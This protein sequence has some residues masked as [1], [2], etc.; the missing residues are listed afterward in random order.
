MIT[1]LLKNLQTTTSNKFVIHCIL[2]IA[3]A[4]SG[5]N[6]VK[7]QVALNYTL[8]QQQI[9]SAFTALPVATKTQIF[10]GL[11]DD[12]APVLVTLPFT[13]YFNGVAQT[14]AWVS[15]NGYIT[16]GSTPSATNY[17]P[18]SSSETYQGA[19]AAFGANLSVGSLATTTIASVVYQLNSVSSFHDTSGGLGNGIFK[20]EWFSFKR[21][22]GPGNDDSN[23]MRMQIW[24]YENGSVIQVKF[25]QQAA[26]SLL[27]TDG[28]GQL[29][30]RG[31][32]NA[33][34]N[35]LSYEPSPAALWPATGFSMTSGTVNT[36]RVQTKRTIYPAA[37]SN[38]QFTWTPKPCLVPT[39]IAV[40]SVLV[41]SATVTWVTPTP[42]PTTYQY[43]VRT[44]GAAG[45]GATG[46]AQS[47][48]SSSP[49]NLTGLTG[50]VNYTVYIRSDC[51]GGTFSS[52]SSG[53]P[54]T[55]LCVGTT[56]PY[57]QY[58]DDGDYVL[59]NVPQCHSIQNIGV[60]PA[61]IWKTSNATASSNTGSF[62]D[63]HL[64]YDATTGT[65]GTD[66]ANVWFFTKG[67]NL[68]AGTTYR[69]SYKYGGSTESATITNKMLVKFG[70]YPSDA[71]MTSGTF[72]ANHDNIKA[73]PLYNV[74][75]FTA[76]AT[77]TFYFGFKAYSAFGNGRIFLDDI[78]ITA[79]GCLKPSGLTANSITY[80]SALM[81]WTAPTSAPG[82]GYAY[83]I[84]TANPIRTAGSFVIGTNY[85]IQSIGSTDYTLIGAASN[86]VGQVFTAT[87]VGT[88]TGTAVAVP[89]NSQIPTGFTSAG[90]TLA[91]LNSL[92][93]NTTYY[94]WV[95][96]NCGPG[97]FSEWSTMQSFTTLV[98]PPYCSISSTDGSTYISNFTTTGGVANINNS[99]TYTIGGYANYSSNFVSQSPSGTI[100]FSTG[101]IATGGVGVA[102]WVDWNNNGIFETGERVYNSAGYLSVSPTTGSITVPP[103]QLIGDYRMRIVS[104]Y[105]ATSPDSCTISPTGPRGEAEDYTFRV[106]S[107]PPALTLS[108]AS[109]TQ[110]AGD[111]SPTVA[112]T[113][114]L[115]NY[116][117]YSWSPAIGV[118]GTAAT[119][120][121]FTSGSTIVYTLTGTQT[122][123]P[124]ATRSV[125]FTYNANPLPTPIVVTPIAP[126]VCPVGGTPVLLTASGG[127][128]SGVSFTPPTDNFN[129]ATSWVAASTSTGGTPANAN[130]IVR[131]SGY[132]PGGS[133]GISSVVSNDGSSY[134]MSNSDAQGSGSTTNVTLT[135]PSFGIPAG[136]TNA[137][138]SFFHYYK[139]W[140]NGS[141]TVQLFDGSSWVTL[142][143]WG[144]TPA[145]VEQ[146]TPTGFVNVSYNLNAYIGVPNLQIRFVYTASWGYVWAID[147][148]VVSGS[149]PSPIRW[150]LTTSPVAN[151]VAVPGLYTSA[152]A[153]PANAYLAGSTATS[154]YALPTATTSYAASASTPIPTV[155][156][157][158]T[159]I[160]V[161]LSPVNTGVAPLNQ[162]LCSSTAANIVLGAPVASVLN[163]EY[164]T[165]FAF[166]TPVT[167]PASNSATL[168]SAQ[169]GTLTA[170]RYFRALVSNG[171]C[172]AYSSV[173]TIT[174]NATTWNG[175]AWS[176]G[177]PDA[178]KMAVFAGNY[179][180]N[181]VV[182]PGDLS[183]CSVVVLSGTINFLASHSL[184]SE[185]EVKVLGG[186]LTFQ[187]TASLV[188]L[189]DVANLPAQSN[190]GN[191][192]DI[193]YFRTTT[194][195]LTYDYTY[196]SSPV[197]PQTLVN[198]SP[199]TLFDKYFSY[200]TVG[201]AWTPVASF[202]LME[203]A[204]GYIIRAPQGHV[205]GTYTGQFFGTPNNG[206]I[207]TPIAIGASR[208]NLIGNPY[209]SAL[210]AD[211]FLSSTLNNTVVDGTIYL[212]THNSPI[213]ANNYNPADYAYYNFSGGTGAGTPA[214]GTNNTTPT[215]KIA[216]GQGFFIE[217]INSGG[218]A[219]FMN[220]MR[221]TASGVNDNFYRSTAT[222][223]T[224]S[225]S[226]SLERNRVWL[227]IFNSTGAYKQTL[228]GYIQNA[229]DG[230]DRG[231][232]GKN[233][234]VGNQVNLYSFVGDT[235]L[236][237]QGKALPFS[238]T[239]IIPLGFKSTVSD[240]Y[241][242]RLS[243]FDG[244]FTSQ[245]VYL[246][247]KVLNV[248]HDLKVS[249][250]TFATN[251]GT[252]DDR[253][254][255]R[256]TSTALNNNVN[257]FNEESVIAYKKNTEIYVNSAMTA[258][259][260]I[261]IYDMRGRLLLEKFNINSNE[262]STQYF[263]SAQQV[264]IVK[265]TN[266]DGKTVSKKII[267]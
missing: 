29:G 15:P 80:N 13:F 128:V 83:Y 136:Y 123:A 150:N 179:V 210:D 263:T 16:F 54:F 46:L 109:S 249:D 219:T 149:A 90:T 203:P 187:N 121:T 127:I 94:V 172:S 99:S 40:S 142:Q 37:A 35:N 52:W 81:T 155:C 166:T 6:S 11:W 100:N 266:V 96:G 92:A 10:T 183:A 250:Y 130:F 124:F 49:L 104:D 207:T 138:F 76:T 145:T 69:V 178:T 241:S 51:G 2:V 102:I 31:A 65:G 229:T 63:E 213:A 88:G 254:Q 22:I 72:L 164:A 18:I 73:S 192:G 233:L 264:I 47:G 113:S 44:S 30:L 110:C 255:L 67:L 231:F 169:I 36:A 122:V 234:D 226:S 181:N 68:V 143:T 134:F 141:A 208:L 86:T 41:T 17:S 45:S 118:S 91:N 147:N 62:G 157:T 184:I 53:T 27:L 211:L 238:D 57:F 194:S 253:F 159:N 215:G 3:L 14:Q 247:D 60:G 23:P 34:F 129:G 256:F 38:R 24:L 144:S 140:I 32:T 146:G 55:T 21:N 201:A 126:V 161:S 242:I 158:N 170:T 189:N 239:D 114:A 257:V 151:G 148:V 160:V 174:V 258:I 230:Y 221:A 61:N 9:S 251:A 107:P 185:N 105:W 204:K 168:T 232:D 70:N 78:E 66:D 43:E 199:L 193:R 267:Y 245:N 186:T 217:A 188:Q 8:Q 223:Q 173:I 260:D 244:L 196:W 209:P 227:D 133:S 93:G 71:A 154:V 139:P 248:I 79:P 42:A 246:E 237:I 119:G 39:S 12:N 59:P 28:F 25:N 48:S 262:F 259:K 95:R 200:N 75:N 190:G 106:V 125:T 103:G 177:T 214:L 191:V 153:I 243:D 82:S 77:G 120:Y 165:D 171:T 131:P 205:S 135:S 198:L 220:S 58:F 64:V 1:N 19:I 195:M 252:F 180:S 197:A 108:L 84:S 265:V 137:T 74:V 152:T 156:T 7:A 115:S 116:N 228:V 5:I 132:N 167:I 112:I 85:E 236:G 224:N 261:A 216:S 117:S 97:D 182:S 206:T 4:F 98:T 89:S 222:A 175:S 87:G 235:K 20:I 225:L 202:N 33:D 162:T 240:S 56:L 111:A 212:W 176:N 50:G 26:N 163:W 218:D 101:F